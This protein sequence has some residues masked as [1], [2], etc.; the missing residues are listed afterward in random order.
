MYCN[1][2]G[3]SY[4]RITMDRITC[5]SPHP[6]INGLHVTHLGKST[7]DTWNMKQQLSTWPEHSRRLITI[8]P[9]N[10]KSIP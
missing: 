8:L 10:V 9:L 6:D 1:S 3:T 2:N 4:S 7:L 5:A